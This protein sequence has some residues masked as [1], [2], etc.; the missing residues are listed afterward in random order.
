MGSLKLED[1]YLTF[2]TNQGEV[3]GKVN[4]VGRVGESFFFLGG[5]T[6]ENGGGKIWV[7]EMVGEK[8]TP[9]FPWGEFSD[10]EMLKIFH[11]VK[12]ERGLG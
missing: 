10:G 9:I 7:F 1:F 12:V 8:L 5:I 11:L 3:V 2:P 4:W 6:F